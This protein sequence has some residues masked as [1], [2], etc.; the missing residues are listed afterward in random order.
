MLI[1]TKAFAGDLWALTKP[2]WQSEERWR[3]GALLATIVA[4]SLGLVW[5]NVLLT[6]WNNAFYNT[7]QDKNE[8]EFWHQLLRFCYLAAAFIV[9]AVYQAYIQQMLQIRWRRWLTEHHVERWLR[10]HVYY[11]LQIA[12]K[13]TDN[14]DQ[15]IAEDIARFV[16]TTLTLSLGLLSAAVTLVSFVAML[17]TLSGSL[18]VK[19]IAIPGYMVWVALIYAIVGTWL[20]HRIGRPLIRLN[21]Q[22]QQFEANFRYSLVRLRENAEGVALYG[23]ESQEARGFGQRFADVVSNWWGIMR[24]QR[25]LNWF[26]NGYAQVAS[27]FPFVVVAPRFFSGA[28]QLGGMMQTASAFG[29]VQGALSWFIN[30]YGGAAGSNSFTEWKA[31]VDRLTS[32]E[33]SLEAIIGEGQGAVVRGAS[34]HETGIAIEGLNLWLPDGTHLLRDLSLD[35]PPGSRTLVTGPSGSGKSTLFRT[36]GGLWPYASGTLL[37]PSGE[38]LL[39]LPQKPYVPIAPLRAA[40][41]YPDAPETYGD[42]RIRDALVACGLN[43]LAS[44]LDEEQHWAQLL[45]GGEQQR[46]AFARALLIQ[47]RWLFMDEATSSL[48]ELAESV[49]YRLMVERLPGTALISITHRPTLAAFHDRRLAFDG[50]GASATLLPAA[51]E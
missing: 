6:E 9:V 36:L 48:D 2:Y 23:G 26:T 22:Q 49:L 41:A 19:G 39:F 44:R 45:S 24:Q 5:I 46:L 32:F 7:L 12:G 40:V 29:Q 15:R 31:V 28:I 20:V 21:F 34:D 8:P 35:L 18:T 43:E 3:S 33:R 10:G 27:V 42:E 13:Q 11:R 4:M 14:P 1:N 47:P 30:V 50:N 38:R 37:F 51:A 17:W 16:D 25:R